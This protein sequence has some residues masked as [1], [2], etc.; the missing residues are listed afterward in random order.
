MHVPRRM[1]THSVCPGPLVRRD[2]L[3]QLDCGLC[4]WRA[5]K[6]QPDNAPGG[7]TDRGGQGPASHLFLLDLSGL[8]IFV[9]FKIQTERMLL[10][11]GKEPIDVGAHQQSL[12]IDR[13]FIDLHPLQRTRHGKT[14][15]DG[16][17]LLACSCSAVA[18]QFHQKRVQGT[19][20]KPN[21]FPARRFHLRLT[22]RFAFRVFFFK[23]KLHALGDRLNCGLVRRHVSADPFHHQRVL[24]W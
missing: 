6:H 24:A 5:T 15:C 2:H 9:L 7:T 20:S 1:G 23:G 8:R 4:V 3:Q 21:G 11:I 12:R 19:H 22:L 17:K 13:P 14:C 10:L 18:L 16:A